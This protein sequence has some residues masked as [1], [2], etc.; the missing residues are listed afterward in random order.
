M[1]CLTMPYIHIVY[2]FIS[3]FTLY[4][5]I[6]VVLCH[7]IVPRSDMQWC[8]VYDFVFNRLRAVRQDM[9]IQ[10]INDSSAVH[11]LEMNIRFHI[12]AGYK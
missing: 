8:R 9:V 1:F 3:S 2:L 11:I 6:S 10:R 12:F 4:N 5:V 7:S